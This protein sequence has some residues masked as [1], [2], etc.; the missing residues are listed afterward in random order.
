MRAG[1]QFRRHF[2]VDAGAVDI[3]LTLDVVSVK[4]DCEANDRNR[5]ENV[6]PQLAD[7]LESGSAI[8]RNDAHRLIRWTDMRKRRTAMSSAS[9]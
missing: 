5:K 4:S 6:G 8:F 1:V 7:S 9:L 3:R 2:V